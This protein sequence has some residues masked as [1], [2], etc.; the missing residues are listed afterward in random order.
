MNGISRFGVNELI[1]LFTLFKPTTAPGLV[2]CELGVDLV[3]VQVF[4]VHL[5]VDADLLEEVVVER[6][7]ADF[8]RDL[9]ILQAAQL[10]QQVGDLLVDFLRLA[11]DQAQVRA[12]FGDRTRPAHFVPGRG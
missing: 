10:G 3:L 7:V 5:E 11:D 12:E 8:D 2:G 9:Q 1:P 6:D 4:D